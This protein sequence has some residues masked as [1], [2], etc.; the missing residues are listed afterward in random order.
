MGMQDVLD[1][2]GKVLLDDARVKNK[3]NRC[4]LGRTMEEIVQEERRHNLSFFHAS[5][6]RR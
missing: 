5:P 6:K 2:Y 4:F 3:W 1:K